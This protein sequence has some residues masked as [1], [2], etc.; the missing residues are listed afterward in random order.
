[1]GAR[2]VEIEV[3]LTLV[4]V[5]GCDPERLLPKS[6]LRQDLGLNEFDIT[7][8]GVQLQERFDIPIPR[9]DFARLETLQALIDYIQLAIKE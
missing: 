7:D 6:R 1:M 8:L 2:D 5:F 9:D 3:K 4:E